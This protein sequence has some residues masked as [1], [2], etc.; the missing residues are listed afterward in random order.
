[1]GCGCN[2]IKVPCDQIIHCGI[3]LSELKIRYKKYVND[4]AKCNSINCIIENEYVVYNNGGSKEG[5]NKSITEQT[6]FI[7]KY[8]GFKNFFDKNKFYFLS[9]L[10]TAIKQKNIFKNNIKNEN[11][12]INQ[13]KIQENIVKQ[14]QKEKK[15]AVNFML[16]LINKFHGIC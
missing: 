14:N 13:K 16:G 8:G 5:I 12:E 7:E 10:I 2:K 6:C 11:I 9:T 4:Q 3:S 15:H 1:M